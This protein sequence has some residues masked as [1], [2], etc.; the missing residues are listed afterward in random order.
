MNMKDLFSNSDK[1]KEEI[2]TDRL[3]IKGNL[4]IWENTS[5]QITNI[6]YV[7]TRQL[8]E[9]KIP[10]FAVILI[11]AGAAMLMVLLPL[12][13]LAIVIGIVWIFSWYWRNQERKKKQFLQIAVNSGQVFEILFYERT[14]LNKVKSILN[15]IIIA[16]GT[17]GKIVH[18]GIKD[19]KFGDGS[20]LFNESKL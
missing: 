17:G 9:E 12:A 13:I 18:I 7:S 8:P 14:F 5:I 19:C 6:S 1:E 3:F 4:I 16:G 10:I 20:K 2:A 11:L 15:T